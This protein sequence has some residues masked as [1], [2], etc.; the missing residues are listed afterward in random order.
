MERRVAVLCDLT[1]LPLILW[2]G[3]FQLPF[4][5][6]G[7]LCNT[8]APCDLALTRGFQQHIF[9]PN[10]QCPIFPSQSSMQTSILGFS[11]GGCSRSVPA[12]LSSK[13]FSEFFTVPVLKDP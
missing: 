6:P 11:S 9:V 1:R 10:S 3:G 5:V 2:V 7:F 8:V 12:I 13:R 4:P